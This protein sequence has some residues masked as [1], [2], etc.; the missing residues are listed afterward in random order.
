MNFLCPQLEHKLHEN[1]GFVSLIN[2]H[3]QHLVYGVF[4]KKKK[5]NY[6]PLSEHA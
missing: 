2:Q 4:K 5:K 6:L 1:K 3:I